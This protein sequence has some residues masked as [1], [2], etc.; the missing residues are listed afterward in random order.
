MANLQFCDTH[1]MVAYLKKSEGSEGFH[2]IVDFLNTSHIRTLDN[3]EVEITATIDGKAKIVTE[4]SIRR[5][6]KLEDSD[7]INT[8]PTTKIFEQLALMGYVSNSDKLTFKKGHF[9]PQLRFLIH[10]I[11]HCLSSKK[12]AWEQFSSNIATT[13]I[14]LAT[15]RKFNFSKLIFDDMETKVPQPSSPTL[16]MPHNLPLPGGHTPGSVESSLKLNELMALCTKLSARVTNLE[17]DLKTTKETY[18]RDYTTLIKKV[19]ELEKKVKESKPTKRRRLQ[20]VLSNEEEDLV[21]EDPFKQGRFDDE[22]TFDADFYKAQVTPTQ[23]SAQREAPSQED[24]PEAQLRVLSATKVLADTAEESVQIYR[25]RAVST[26]S[27]RLSAA[28]ESVSTTGISMPISTAGKIQEINISIP[29]P[30]AVKDKGKGK[31]EEAKD[32]QTKRTKLQQEQDW[33]G[34]EA[35]RLQAEEQDKYSKVDQAKMLVDLINQRKRYFATQKAEAKRNKPMTQAQQRTYM[36]NYIK[37]MGSYTLKQLK[38]LSFDEIRELFETT[39]KR[40][41][42]FIPMETA[43]EL[44]T[45]SAQAILTDSAK[46]GSSKRA[47]EAE[48]DYKGSKRLF[49]PDA[50]D[51]LW[52][53][54]RYMHDPL[55]WRLYDTCGVHHVSTE[56]VMDIFMLQLKRLSFDELKNLFEATMRRV[57]T[58]VTMET[59]IRRGVPELV[60]DMYKDQKHLFGRKLHFLALLVMSKFIRICIS[61]VILEVLLSESLRFEYEL[62]LELLSSLPV[63]TDTPL[64]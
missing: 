59:E 23:V 48:L 20:I 41:N 37:H 21:L 46:V 12:T 44:A 27:G 15:N 7:G 16:S 61:F 30:V 25:R 19:K 38:K 52:K 5:H 50:D 47:A 53:L 45:G 63:K 13:I 40:V 39:M 11:L 9:S 34:Y 17:D 2:Q 57:S 32:E 60:A 28:E 62:M 4:A 29:S 51:T 6:L 33:L 55:T 54:Q 14:C 43:S 64:D 1:N 58:F 18:S 10:T 24:Q 31:M 26:G 42:T 8:L 49:E 3:G 22:T 35:A 36:S 56:R